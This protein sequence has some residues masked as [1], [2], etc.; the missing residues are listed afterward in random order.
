V[1]AI[2]FNI[3][4][5]TIWSC[6]L[7]GTRA[8]PE[9]QDSGRQRFNPDQPRPELAN[10]FKQT[11]GEIIDQVR[12]PRLAYR[13]TLNA[14][15]ADQ[16]GYLCFPFG[17]LNLIAHERGLTIDQFTTASFSKKALGFSGD[18]FDACETI[19]GRPEKWDRDAKLAAL[20]A[21]MV[22]DA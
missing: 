11:F 16:I 3:S 19:K 7:K 10:Y 1:T 4:K 8:A 6:V 13:L 17:I 2:G 20:S 5:G 18:K 14:T 12:I 15:R 22:L 9:V 21:W